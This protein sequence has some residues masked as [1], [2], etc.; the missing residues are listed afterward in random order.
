MI[1]TLSKRNGR[2]LLCFL[3]TLILLVCAAFTVGQSA[4]AA[5]TPTSLGLAAHGIKAHRDGWKYQYGGKGQT[6]GDTRVSDCAGLLYAYFSD[7]GSLG[8][9]QGGATGQVK[10]NCVFSNDI[11]EGIP[12]IHGLALTMPDHIEPSTGIY[13]H[14]GIYLGNNE[15]AD[16]SDSTYNMLRKPVVGS[17]REWTAW[18]VFDNGMKYPVEGWYALDGKMVHYTDYEYDVSTTIDG[19]TIGSDGYAYNSD[20]SFAAVNTSLLSDRYVP[21]SQVVNHLK[22]KY[23]GKDSTYEIIYGGTSSED[24]P[25]LGY[26]GKITGDGVNLRKEASTKSAVVTTLSLNTQINILRE[27]VGEVIT[28]KGVSSSKWYE[29]TA[30][31]G[32]RG[33]VSA[34]YASHVSTAPTITC[35][36]GYVTISTEYTGGTIYFTT[37]NTAPDEKSE[38][39]AGPLYNM[40]GYTYRAVVI[41][42]NL[43]SDEAMATVLSNGS[44]FTDFTSAN[45]YFGVVD[46]A[47]SAGIFNGNGNGTFTPG[48]NITR[49]QFVMA[50][51]NLDGVELS[52]IDGN[53]TSF[54]DINSLSKTMKQAVAWAYAKGYVTGVSPTAFHPDAS[55]TREQMCSIIAR[56]ADLEKE[57]APV[58]FADDS[59]ISGWAKDAV[60]ACR[61]ADLID[62]VGN[63]KFSPKGTAIRAE[64]C[65][66]M[67]RFHERPVIDVNP[68]NAVSE[69]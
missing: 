18:H 22:G 52:S 11:S 63:N 53:G 66:V 4:F 42:G 48:K 35:K 7:T 1:R 40:T 25:Q 57:E 5:T 34:L 46:K 15:A 23:S 41:Q 12:N 29:A 13:G 64:A 39:Y 28:A 17:G 49:A 60:Y 16:N 45:W 26:N 19:Y 58:L 55:I 51:A 50:L 6:V 30:P 21:A 56:Y 62:G 44:V 31:G 61:K 9:C 65:A 38:L 33:Y 20:G 69:E 37:D 59:R 14:I 3:L 67:V 47:V 32:N 24:P 43:K 36:D 2:R 27:V 68:G 10:N 8:N 54:R